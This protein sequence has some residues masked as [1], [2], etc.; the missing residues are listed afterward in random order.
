MQNDIVSNI[1]DKYNSISGFFN[2]RQK[3]LWAVAE[4]KSLGR[5]G[6][7]A[8]HR[9]TGISIVTIRKGIQELNAPEQHVASQRV[10]KPGGGKKK[11]TARQPHLLDALQ[12]H[13]E[14]STRGDP[15]SPFRIFRQSK[16]RFGLRKND[17]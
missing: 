8:V 15:M 11:I 4:S 7:S 16:S 6:I 5:G 1:R 9:A 17:R 12:L 3:R 13:L 2:E 10:R 14:S